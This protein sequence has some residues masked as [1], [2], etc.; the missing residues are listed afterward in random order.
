MFLDG[1]FSELPDYVDVDLED[2][3]IEDIEAMEQKKREAIAS[4]VGY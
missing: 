4:K 1:I 2:A 3:H